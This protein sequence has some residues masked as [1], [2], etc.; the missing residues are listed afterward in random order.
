M[1]DW[2]EKP[3]KEPINEGKPPNSNKELRRKI[4]GCWGRN[5]DRKVVDKKPSN[6]EGV[7]GRKLTSYN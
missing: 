3:D 1:G 2:W 6:L 5:I 4:D 7:L